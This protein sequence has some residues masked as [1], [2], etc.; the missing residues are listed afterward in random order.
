[1]MSSLA[2][3]LVVLLINATEAEFSRQIYF[4]RR[5][6]AGRRRYNDLQRRAEP[7]EGR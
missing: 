5:N 2:Q 4:K 6:L 7:L 1:M 3:F